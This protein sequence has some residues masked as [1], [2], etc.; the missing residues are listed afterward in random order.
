MKQQAQW[1]FFSPSRPW[2]IVSTCICRQCVWPVFSWGQDCEADKTH[3][4]RR[5]WIFD[6][7]QCCLLCLERM[8][9]LH[10]LNSCFL[11][12]NTPFCCGN[13]SAM[14]VWWECLNSGG[15]DTLRRAKLLQFYKVNC[16]KVFVYV[17]VCITDVKS[18]GLLWCYSHAGWRSWC[19]TVCITL[20]C[21]VLSKYR[22][23]SIVKPTWW[24]FYSIYVL[25]IVHVSSI[26][27]SSSGGA[28]QTTL[29]KLHAC[30]VSWLHQD[31]SGV[32]SWHNTHAIC[33][34]SFVQSLLRMSK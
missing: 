11:I 25:R 18:V 28:A 2:V 15:S 20:N 19:Y 12:S 24:T 6:V 30:Y 13:F 26:T 29:G 21:S 31:W 33:Q 32:A 17:Y 5:S 1:C 27:S 22:I 23:V 4:V 8:M 14:T 16:S 3:Y 7:F 9:M 34:L 10:V